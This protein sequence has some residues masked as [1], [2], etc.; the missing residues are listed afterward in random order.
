VTNTAAVRAFQSAAIDGR[1][2]S[3]Y[4]L[5]LRACCLPG[6]MVTATLRHDTSPP[7]HLTRACASGHTALVTCTMVDT[8]R[9]TRSGR[10]S[11]AVRNVG[12]INMDYTPTCVASGAV[13][14]CAFEATVVPVAAGAV[15]GVAVAYVAGTSSGPGTVTIDLDGGGLDD[16]VGVV[17]V[18]VAGNGQ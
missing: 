15:G 7:Q 13:L 2:R 9:T 1:V 8:I 12:A 4:W 17:A 10:M 14:S 6:L 11:V 16:V 18:T 5:A 3:R